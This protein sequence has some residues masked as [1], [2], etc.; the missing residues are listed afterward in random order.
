MIWSDLDQKMVPGMVVLIPLPRRDTLGMTEDDVRE[1]YIHD[2]G[3]EYKRLHGG[4]TAVHDAAF[5]LPHLRPGM[6]LLDCGCGPGSI[7][8]GL[9]AVVAPGEVVAIDIAETQLESARRLAAQR[10]IENIQFRRGT[11][12]ELPVADASFDAT[13]AHNVL[14]HLRDPDVALAEMYRVL[15]PGGV[16]GIRDDDWSAYLLEP[17]STLRT[18]G[19]ELILRGVEHN[20]GNFR[21][22]RHHVKLLREAGF[23][24]I[25]GHASAGGS[26]TSES[27]NEFA[28][29]LVRQ[30]KDPVFEKIVL[31][32]AWTDQHTLDSIAADVRAWAAEPDAFLAFVKC[33]AV[34]RR[35]RA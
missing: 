31:G 29:V 35:P 30:L 17:T 12:Y 26:G 19:I 4:R 8:V 7:T 16:V 33:A 10:Q 21:S 14:E 22:A 27:V 28:A 6:R 11:I 20:G 1:T 23:V 15:K 5:F 13:F 18:L 3:D 34:G 9:A 25:E 2:Y 24:D 32:E